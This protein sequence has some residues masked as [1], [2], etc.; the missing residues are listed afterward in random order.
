M[1][2][3]EREIADELALHTEAYAEV[4]KQYIA[5]TRDPETSPE[6]LKVKHIDVVGAEAACEFWKKELAELKNRSFWSKVEE[7]FMN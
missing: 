2:A 4:A 1:F 5:M 7:N 3:D 6:E